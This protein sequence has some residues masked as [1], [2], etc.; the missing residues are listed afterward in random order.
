EPF[1]GIDDVK[2]GMTFTAKGPEGQ[3]QQVIVE[4]VSEAGIKVNA[5]HPLAGKV[6]QFDIAVEEVRAPTPEDLDEFTKSI[7]EV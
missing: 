6:L 1:N 4:E 5:N 2:P 3:V 7:D